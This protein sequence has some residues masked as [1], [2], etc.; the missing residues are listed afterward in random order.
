MKPA[1]FDYHAPRTVDEAVSLL[2]E[3]ACQDGRVI[4][5]GQSFV[6]MMAFRL[7]RPSHL[8]DI[9]RIGEL[10]R[11]SVEDATLHIGAT[12]RHAALESMAGGDTL[13]CLLREVAR[14]VAHPPIRNRGTFCGSLVHADPA[15][16]WCLVAATLDA[17]I[18][19]RSARGDR[20]I[21]AADFFQGVMT[22]SLAA[23]ELVMECRI[24]PLADDARFG[25]FE[26][27]RRAGD[28]AMAAALVTYR[29]H[30]GR[31]AE[32][33][34]GLG[35]VEPFPRRLPWVEARLAGEVPDS[36]CF[37]AAAAAAAERVEPMQDN[38]IDT[39]LRRHLVSAVT[40]RA[41]QR[42]LL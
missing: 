20:A 3:F 40:L 16:E 2:A 10:D 12:V 42:S 37:R 32:P 35:G 13:G 5:G 41:L 38:R 8:I 14:F 6:P 30:D 19:S 27:S 39:D 31:I 24:P 15:A 25:F 26:A 18:L 21:A 7:A 17:M 29:L 23:D 33:H 36:E 1:P 28:F 22:T 11:L 4:A 34:I 9:N